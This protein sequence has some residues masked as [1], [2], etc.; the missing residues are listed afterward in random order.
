MPLINFSRTFPMR[1]CVQ[2]YHIVRDSSQQ[3]RVNFFHTPT[4]KPLQRVTTRRSIKVSR[5]WRKEKSDLE[6]FT[7]IIRTR[8]NTVTRTTYSRGHSH[9]FAKRHF[10]RKHISWTFYES[11]LARFA[12]MRRRVHTYNT[13]DAAQIYSQFS[14]SFD[15]N[16]TPY[17]FY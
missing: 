11:R 17:V 14:I 16:N 8:R 2:L 1:P 9:A 10:P 3:T 12:F 7:T 4:R 5:V 15:Y 13:A 6:R